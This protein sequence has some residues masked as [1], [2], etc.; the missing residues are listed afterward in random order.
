MLKIGFK[1][2][3]RQ[4]DADD[5]AGIL[6]RTVLESVC[7]RVQSKPMGI[8]DPETGECPAIIV[9]PPELCLF[10]PSQPGVTSHANTVARK[11]YSRLLDEC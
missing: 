5:F 8:G 2:N 4:V 3:G 9:A 6:E 1:I 7:E 11:G 10:R